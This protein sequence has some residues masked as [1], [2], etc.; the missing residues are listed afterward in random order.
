MKTVILG[1]TGGIAAI[2]IP[3]LIRALKKAH[4]QPIVIMTD[5]ATH[6]ISPDRMKMA[7]GKKVYVKL[8][9]KEFNAK[10]TVALKTID[11]ITLA[12]KA[13]LYIIVPATANSIAKLSAGIADDYVTT[14]ALAARCPILIFPSMNSYMWTHPATI[15]NVNKLKSYGYTIINPSTG[16][17][18]CGDIGAGRL[19]DVMV[20]RD[21]ILALLKKTKILNNKIIIVTS[22]AT[23]EFIDDVRYITNNSS[24]KM[25]AALS[26]AAYLYG[27]NV[28]LLR[29]KK[30]I[31]PRYHVKQE[32]Y[33]SADELTQLMNHYLPKADICI[34]CA[35]VSDYKVLRPRH[36]K[37]LSNKSL[38]F[39]LTPRTKI[40]DTI[41]RIKPTIYLAAFK[42]EWN[43]SASKLC[44]IA[45]NRL[46]GSHADMIIANDVGK[47]GIGFGSD[48]NDVYIVTRASTPIHISLRSKSEIASRI[49]DE[50]VKNIC[51]ITVSA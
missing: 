3:E 46:L 50:I 11:H 22:G 39:E 18:A 37:T 24:G 45:K 42:A 5:S 41:K 31:S 49:I 38:P 13:S 23:K 47:P 32:E 7:T 44:T 14:F 51:P 34:H 30:S 17:L 20:M 6:I 40:L 12:K 9:P 10:N 33:E 29:A 48:Y 15:E 8:F 26:D 1:V 21:E 19:P 28:V 35:A 25:G 43:V 36:G 2:R 4:V 16:Q 27:A